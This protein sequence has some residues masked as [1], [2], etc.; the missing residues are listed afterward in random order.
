MIPVS[1]PPLTSGCFLSLLVMGQM[2]QIATVVTATA[3]PS[4]LLYITGHSEGCEVGAYAL[5]IP[6]E[7][8]E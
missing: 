3:R 4:F 1:R 8:L 6:S 7:V 5:L 2:P